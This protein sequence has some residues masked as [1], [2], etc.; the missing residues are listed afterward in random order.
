MQRCY[1]SR[2]ALISEWNQ[3]APANYRNS[4]RDLVSKC[5][6]QGD[7]QGDVTELRHEL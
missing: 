2:Q 6:V 3:D 7:R 4:A 5:H 1:D